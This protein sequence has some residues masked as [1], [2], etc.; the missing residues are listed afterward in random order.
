VD[1][2]EQGWALTLE[3]RFPSPSGLVRN[4][5]GLF[6]LFARVESQ[7]RMG[8]RNGGELLGCGVKLGKPCTVDEV[9]DVHGVSSV[10]YGNGNRHVYSG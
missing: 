1:G 2:V 5:M 7:R 6:V 3:T 8:W 9:G 10:W 4:R